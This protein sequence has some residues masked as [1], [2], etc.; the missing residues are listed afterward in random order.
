MVH[1]EA[2]AR[3]GEIAEW[4][5]DFD[6]S[7]E[8]GLFDL[9]SGQLQLG[10]SLRSSFAIARLEPVR[11]ISHT[12]KCD[13]LK[14]LLIECGAKRRASMALEVD[15]RLKGHQRLEGSLEADRSRLDR[16]PDR[17][18]RHDRSD[19]IGEFRLLRGRDVLDQMGRAFSEGWRGRSMGW[20]GV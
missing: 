14:Q 11:T 15:Q 6:K 4:H 3:V 19:Q 20:S 1:R 9:L 8:L 13:G 7:F 17:G 18:L 2:S 16:L 10:V 5:L 12:V